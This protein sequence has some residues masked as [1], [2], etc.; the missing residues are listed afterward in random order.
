[1]SDRLLRLQLE[2]VKLE[3][4]IEGYNLRICN[5]SRERERQFAI[6]CEDYNPPLE[7][8]KE[9]VKIDKEIK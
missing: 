8:E 9:I 4:A 2:S 1:M 6:Y 3:E 5:L 7:L